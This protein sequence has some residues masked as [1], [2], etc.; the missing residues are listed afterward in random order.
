[1][2]AGEK[3][4]SLIHGRAAES[5]IFVAAEAAGLRSIRE[6]GERLV[7]EG[8]TSPEEVIRVTREWRRASPFRASLPPRGLGRAWGGPPHVRYA[9]VVP[10]SSSKR[11]MR[12][13]SRRPACS[14]PKTPQAARAQ[15]RAVAGPAGHRP[16]VAAGAAGRRAAPVARVFHATGLAVW[17]RQLAGLVGPGLP[18]ER[19]L[20][21][22]GD[23]PRP[24]AA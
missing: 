2:V 18:L 15:L 3:V 9:W 13:A 16:V 10:A 20:T 5:Q 8:I 7:D 6:D 24:Q 4:R 22:L 1:M 23:E 12:R 11:S 17:T 21:A 14:T 19:A